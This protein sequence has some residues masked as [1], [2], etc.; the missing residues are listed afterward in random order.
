MASFLGLKV[1]SASH[2]GLNSVIIIIIV[3]SA[4][5]MPYRPIFYIYSDIILHC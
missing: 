2:F 5:E 4:L 3:Q 1:C